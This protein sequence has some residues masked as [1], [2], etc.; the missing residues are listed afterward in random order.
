MNLTFLN[1]IKLLF[2]YTFS[3][4]LSI[5]IFLFSALLFVLLIV[6]M[7]R[8]EKIVTYCAIGVYIGLLIGTIIAYREYV[9]LCVK[10]FFKLII[11]YICFPTTVAFFFTV[12][13]VTIIMIYT[14]FSKN[15]SNFKRVINYLVFSFTYYFFISFIALTAYNN[16]D[17]NSN[18]ALY[19]NNYVL[20]IVQASNILLLC[21]FI[22]TLLYRLNIFLKKK[23]D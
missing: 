2:Q 5:E 20:V 22:F 3:S 10:S 18:V 12:L 23:F 11:T 21:W 8:R 16:I 1:K 6:N 13:A 19:T 4:F 15:I 9:A 17:L 7:K 14:L